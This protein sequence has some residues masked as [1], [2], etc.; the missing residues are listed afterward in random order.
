MTTKE[1]RKEYDGPRLDRTPGLHEAN[2]ARWAGWLLPA[3]T[4]LL[5]AI[6]SIYPRGVNDLWWQLKTGEL[7]WTGR[8]VPRSDVFSHTAAGQPWHV[9]EWLAELLIFALYRGICPGA[10]VAYKIV[11][12]TLVFA[13]VLWRCCQIGRASCRERV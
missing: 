2:V 10:L 6:L 5:V 1:R 11:G 12:Y 4:L 8:S 9:Q 3:V 7:I 13:L